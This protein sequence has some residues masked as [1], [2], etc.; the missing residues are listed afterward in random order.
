MIIVHYLPYY[1]GIE[2]DAIDKSFLTKATLHEVL[3]PFRVSKWALR[4]RVSHK[5]FLHLGI[6]RYESEARRYD[7]GVDADEIGAWGVREE[8]AEDEYY[9]NE[10]VRLVQP[11]GSG[12]PAGGVDDEEWGS[13]PWPESFG[14]G[15]GVD[16]QSA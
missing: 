8:T 13:V 15:P 16:S 1:W 3:P 12:G 4:I 11:S 14:T 5:H 7:L 10:S 2:T 9:D 6:Y